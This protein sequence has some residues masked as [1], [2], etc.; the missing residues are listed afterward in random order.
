MMAGGAET[1]VARG[2]D[3]D[4]PYD[5]LSFVPTLLGLM[6]RCEPELPGPLIREAGQMPCG[7][8]TR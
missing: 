1:G 5:S 3:I 7:P 6:A 2:I 8:N 4:E